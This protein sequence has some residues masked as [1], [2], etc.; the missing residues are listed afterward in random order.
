MAATEGVPAVDYRIPPTDSACS[1]GSLNAPPAPT[2]VGVGNG[3]GNGGGDGSVLPPMVPGQDG[4]DALVAALPRHPGL[5]LVCICAQEFKGMTRHA[6][7]MA[8]EGTT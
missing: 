6:V 2:A 4:Y 1:A 7:V 3:V 5:R 8:R